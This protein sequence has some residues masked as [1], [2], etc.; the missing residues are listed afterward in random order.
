MWPTDRAAR[1]W[2]IVPA[3][4][5]AALLGGCADIYYD[6][7]ETVTFHAGDAVASNKIVHMID[8]WPRAAANRNIESNGERMQRAVERYRKNKT[9]PL[10]TTSTSSAGFAPAKPEGE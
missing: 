4:A 9:T 10:Q 7:R 3:L 8:P 2:S 6:R 5:V 1:A